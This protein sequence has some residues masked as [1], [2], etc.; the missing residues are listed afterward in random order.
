M[1]SITLRR[2]A[3]PVLAGI[4]TSAAVAAFGLAGES[5]SQAVPQAPTPTGQVAGQLT[6]DNGKAI[7]ILSFSVGGTSPTTIGSGGG[8]GAG[9]V[10]LS[11]LSLMKAVDAQTPPLYLSM[12][13]GHHFQN[14]IFTAQWGTGGSAATLKYELE[15][16]LVE[17]L[18]QSGAGGAA[19]T[20]S[21]SLTFG[22]VRWTYTDAAGS[23]TGSWNII[24]NT[25]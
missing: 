9:K 2:L 13:S 24:E 14:A 4:V 7:P 18:Q 8:A 5:S 12:A 20:E 21:L 15:Q 11:S 10:S 16:V 17:S 1:R 19:P 23:T 6:L 25:Q 22:K 3:L